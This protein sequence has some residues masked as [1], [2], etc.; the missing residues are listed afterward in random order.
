MKRNQKGFTIIEV[1]LVLLVLAV[2]GFGGYYIWHTQK[3]NKTTASST[4]ASAPTK[5]STDPTAGWQTYN[6]D[7]ASF[8]YPSGWTATRNDNTN[9]P[10]TKNIDLVGP[11]DTAISKSLEGG[12]TSKDGTIDMAIF[13]A[14][15][16]G[17]SCKVYDVLPLSMPGNKNAK[18]AIT[19]ATGVNEDPTTPAAAIVITDGSASVGATTLKDGITVGS[20]NVGISAQI[21]GGFRISDVSAFE[22]SQSLQELIKILNTMTIK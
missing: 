4:N 21:G 13:K 1:S 17:C 19:S 14:I 10:G 12:A 8:K 11:S 20:D 16:P 6:D 22:K 5:V 15:D 3:S 7:F 9:L 18:L 2:A